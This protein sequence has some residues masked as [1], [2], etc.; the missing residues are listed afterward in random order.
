M[1]IHTATNMDREFRTAI[2]HGAA[3]T[4]EVRMARVLFE[5]DAIDTA[6]RNV[7]HA[8]GAAARIIASGVIVTTGQVRTLYPNGGSVY[9]L[10]NAAVSAAA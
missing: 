7:G 2:A 6:P 1:S 10:V 8:L 3:T 9:N 4:D 5:V